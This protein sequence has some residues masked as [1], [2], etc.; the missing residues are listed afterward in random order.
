MAPRRDWALLRLRLAAA[1]PASCT[2]E[3]ARPRRR[4][5]T[6][7]GTSSWPSAS[8]SPAA[9]SSPDPPLPRE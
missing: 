9:S 2:G 3:G 5:T 4:R 7:R 6:R 8:S 1:F